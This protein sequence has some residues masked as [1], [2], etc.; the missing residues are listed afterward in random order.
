MWMCYQS[1]DSTFEMSQ[2]LDCYWSRTNYLLLLHPGSVCSRASN[3][4]S[5]RFHNYTIS[6]L[7]TVRAMSVLH[8]VFHVKALVCAFNQEKALVVWTIVLSFNTYTGSC[9][10]PRRRCSR[11]PHHRRGGRAHSG[12]P[13]TGSRA[14]GRGALRAEQGGHAGQYNNIVTCTDTLPSLV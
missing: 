8:S 11:T 10:R 9:P 2:F 3:K 1:R 5:R 14:P 6:H 13:G 4:D 7:L 12:R